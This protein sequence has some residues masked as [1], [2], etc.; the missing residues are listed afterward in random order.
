MVII[1]PW[2]YRGYYSTKFG[3]TYD[4]SESA[5]YS[6]IWSPPSDNNHIW[7]LETLQREGFSYGFTPNP[8]PGDI[9]PLPGFVLFLSRRLCQALK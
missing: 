3:K 4:F 5:G 9:E 7:K 8:G 6:F 1:P 2:E